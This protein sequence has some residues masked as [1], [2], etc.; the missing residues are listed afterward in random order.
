MSSIIS[1]AYNIIGIG[2]SFIFS[3]SVSVRNTQIKII[4]LAL[5]STK[6]LNEVFNANHIS[7]V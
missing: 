4:C 5:V 6:K 3:I 1:K 7:I 2:I